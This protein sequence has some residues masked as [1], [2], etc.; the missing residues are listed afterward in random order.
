M[1]RHKSIHLKG[2]K[3]RRKKSAPTD[4]VL[5]KQ[6]KVI[7]ENT[8]EKSLK[9]DECTK[10]FADKMKLY[11]HKLTHLPKKYEC[12]KCGKK[13]HAPYLL[14]EHMFTHTSGTPYT[15]DIC[16]KSLTRLEYLIEHKKRVHNQIQM[17]TFAC[18]IC[19]QDFMSNHE[20]DVH[21]MVHVDELRFREHFISWY[22]SFIKRNLDR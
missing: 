6:S 1:K 15:C 12:D 3:F 18:K 9:C 21:R 2:V 11:Y 22:F 13:Y 19:E 20:L 7:Q 5:K 10:Y 17:K 14:R 16:N 4:I 8:E